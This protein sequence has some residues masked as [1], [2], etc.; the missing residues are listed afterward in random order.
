[1]ELLFV[2]GRFSTADAE[3]TAQILST[4]VLALPFMSV[5]GLI[6]NAF[7]SISDYGTPVYGMTVQWCA[8][9]VGG[10][11]F[12]PSYGVQGLA[13]ASVVAQGLHTL[14]LGWLLTRKCSGR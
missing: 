8:L 1:V 7:Y 14:M 9:A 5:Y 4:L 10:S 6:R 3:I 2:R 13:L 12:I 11:L